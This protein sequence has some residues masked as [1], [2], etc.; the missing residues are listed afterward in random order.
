MSLKVHLPTGDFVCPKCGTVVKESDKKCPK[1]GEPFEGV[2]EG[3]RCPNCGTINDIDAAI[4]VSCGYS[5]E[6]EASF[7]RSDDEFLQKLLNWSKTLAEKENE[8]YQEE[9]EQ[10]V[11]VFK[12]VTGLSLE[13]A[14]KEGE[15]DWKRKIDRNREFLKSMMELLEEEKSG[16]EK[17]ANNSRKK[18]TK[19][20]LEEEADAI[21]QEIKGLR[22]AYGDLE[23]IEKW[24]DA[25]IERLENEGIEKERDLRKE[26]AKVRKESI[27]REEELR[28]HINEQN[29]EIEQLRK[30]LSESAGAASLIGEWT[31]LEKRIEEELKELEPKEKDEKIS[32]YIFETEKEMKTILDAIRMRAQEEEELKRL[33]KVL[34][35][36]FDALPDRIVKKFAESEDFRLYERILDR[37]HVGE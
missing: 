6:K 10:V 15:V 20:A 17:K 5:F 2:R 28:N 21:G 12:K 1:C 8:E 27:A 19:R 3:K 36:L 14:D 22:R 9:A 25:Q 37:Y 34:D 26:I 4:C 11:N 13:E 31:A 16:I 32:D 35:D 23:D 18:D 33:L 30:R 24:F 7:E 29:A